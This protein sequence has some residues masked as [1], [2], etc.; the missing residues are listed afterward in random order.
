MI[1][2]IIRI[3]NSKGIRIPKVLLDQSGLHDE[4]ELEVQDRRLIIR[5]RRSIR[6]GWDKAFRTM[7]ENKDDELIDNNF[8]RGQSSWDEKEWEW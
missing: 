5:P 1:A 2:R 6:E 4:V 8:L 3:G 7:A